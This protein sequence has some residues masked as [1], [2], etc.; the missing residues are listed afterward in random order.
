MVLATKTGLAKKARSATLAAPMND[1]SFSGMKPMFSSGSGLLAARIRITQS[2][3]PPT[4]GSVATRSSMSS[5]PY[6]LNLI[7]P[8]CG[9]R[10][11]EMSRSDM[12]LR[13]EVTAR[14][15]RRGIVV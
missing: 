12:I 14:A 6:F 8:S 10:R 3:S 11:S 1:E 4:V 2:S 13:R 7:L 9:S 5:A 15:Q